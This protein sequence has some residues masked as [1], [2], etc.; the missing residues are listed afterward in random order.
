MG[1]SL[2]E[3]AVKC[4]KLALSRYFEMA[5]SRKL[6]AQV[7]IQYGK[8]SGLYRAEIKE[9]RKRLGI[10]SVNEEGVHWW[11]WPDD[12][13]PGDVNTELSNEFGRK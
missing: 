7:V 12:S 1:R 11:V 8:T 4:A 3:Q 10:Q 2:D 13:R 6:P 5:G 9:A